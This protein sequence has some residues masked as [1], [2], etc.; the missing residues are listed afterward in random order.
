[1]IVLELCASTSARCTIRYTRPI[2]EKGDRVQYNAV[3]HHIGMD[4]LRVVYPLK[5]AKWIPAALFTCEK[6][7]PSSWRNS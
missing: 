6:R 4:F 1:M 3:A 7:N 5:R 2:L